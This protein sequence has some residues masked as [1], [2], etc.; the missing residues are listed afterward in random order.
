MQARSPFAQDAYERARADVVGLKA[1]L[2]D[3]SIDGIVSEIL[4]RIK[5]RGAAGNTSINAPSP[6][7]V[8]KLAYAL[9]SDDDQD[10]AR[11]IQGVREDGASLDAVYLNYLAEAADLLGEWWKE[12]HVSFVEV[13]V[14]TS[15]IYSIMRGLSHLFVPR[16]PV[17][18]KSAIFASVPDET[19][20]LG[21]TMARD[22]FAKEGWDID[23]Q[24]GK[25]HDELVNYIADSNCLI[26]GLS[27]AGRHSAPALAKLVLALHISNP[28]ARI[29]VNGHVTNE[30]SD[31]VALMGVDGVANDVETA[32]DMMNAAWSQ[33]Q[34]HASKA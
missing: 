12:D 10:G 5:A 13:A 11:F 8:E 30:A 1:H 27:A 29:F 34:R 4:T 31:L 2:P 24:V 6:A 32:R 33:A 21:V 28:A 18:V 22:I 9:I 15:R 20:T 7:Q 17:E 19:H 25:S 23:L 14:G 3:A 26:V 16:G